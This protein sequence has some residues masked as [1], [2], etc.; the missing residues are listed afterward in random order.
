MQIDVFTANLENADDARNRFN[1]WLDAQGG[2]PDFV[3]LHQSVTVLDFGLAALLPD[4]V[5]VHGA[6]SCLGVMSGD[7]P[8][9][10][11]GAGA[12]AIWDANGDY[13]TALSEFGS[14]PRSA[15][16]AA[17]ADALL[18]AD[19][20]GESPDLI[21][22]SASPGSEE[23]VLA[24]VEDVVGQNVPI[25]G[26]SA[27]DNSVSGE[28][29]VFDRTDIEANGVIVSVLFPSTP[30]S[31]A[32]HNGYAPTTH[33]GTVTAASGRLL[34][35]I[36]GRL[37]ADVYRDWIGAGAIPESVTETTAILS[38]STLSPLGQYLESVGDVPYYLLAHPAGLTPEGALELFA[39]VDVGDRLTLM[40]GAPDQLTQRAGKVASL[41]AQSANMEPNKIAGA[42]MVYCGGCMLAVQDRLTDVT[43]GVTEALPNVPYLGIFTFGEQGV[44]LDGRNRHGNLM[45]SAV[46]FS[47]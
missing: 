43:D 9:T 29:R 7:G 19:R 25:L 42:L 3:A 44:V 47:A 30:I 23:L 33:S 32:Y 39:D 22:I 1:A 17:T 11:N 14:D 36:D 10:E 2:T 16:A 21:W 13:G 26:G 45:I 27:A 5:A 15:A 40:R 24:G 12:F 41:A 4:T 6:T 46:V 18:A 28:W 38:E 34:Q 35:E 20:P 31:F 37:A 8:C